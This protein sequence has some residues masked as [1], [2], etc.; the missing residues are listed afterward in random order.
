MIKD[1]AIEEGPGSGFEPEEEGT[2]RQGFLIVTTGSTLRIVLRHDRMGDDE[3]TVVLIVA[4]LGRG[5]RSSRNLDK[6]SAG[7]LIGSPVRE[8]LR[9]LPVCDLNYYSVYV[10]LLPA[11][12]CIFF[13]L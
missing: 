7:L 2:S 6:I 12:K 9:T 10:C 4:E 13:Y 3:L 11:Y 8:P 5:H 1:V